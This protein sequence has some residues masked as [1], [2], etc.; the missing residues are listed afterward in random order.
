MYPEFPD[1]DANFAN[2]Y[3]NPTTAEFPLVYIS[4]PSAKDPDFENRYPGRSTVEVLTLGA[5]QDFSEWDQS[6][7][8]NRG[9][10][11]DLLKESIAQ[12]L[13]EVLY[14]KLPHLRGKVDYYELSTPLSTK[15]FVNYKYGEIYGLAHTPD[16]FKNTDL[17]VSTP[18]KDFYLT[19]QDLISCGVAGAAMSAMTTAAVLRGRGIIKKIMNNGS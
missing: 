11:Y 16:R 10:K 9:E 19:G 1:H 18:I 5:Y 2:Y 14:T 12:R 6:K 15:N 8:K 17:N 3:K 4:F 7:W 13:L